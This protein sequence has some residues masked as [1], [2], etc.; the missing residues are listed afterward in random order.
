MVAEGYPSLKSIFFS[1]AGRRRMHQFGATIAAS[2]GFHGR[3]ESWHPKKHPKRHLCGH[4]CWWFKHP[5][6]F[7]PGLFLMFYTSQ[8]V[9]DFSP[10]IVCPDLVDF[11]LSQVKH[12]VPSWELIYPVKS[13]L[14]RW[15]SFSFAGTCWFPGGYIALILLRKEPSLDL[16]YIWNLWTSSILG[17]EFSKRRPKLHSKHGSFGF[18]VV[19]HM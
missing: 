16:T 8:P 1:M 7:Q 6:N 10:S 2:C 11:F 9:Q 12:I 3:D 17:F 19:E 14:W 15:F 4:Y 18:Q 13:Q 5:F